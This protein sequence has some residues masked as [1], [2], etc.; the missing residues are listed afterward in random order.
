MSDFSAT[1]NDNPPTPI[2]DTANQP[3]NSRDIDEIYSCAM[4][5]MHKKHSDQDAKGIKGPLMK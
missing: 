1:V 5:A 3:L 2:E 4:L